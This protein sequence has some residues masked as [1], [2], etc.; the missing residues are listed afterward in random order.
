MATPSI[1]IIPSIF[2]QGVLGS[3]LPLNGAAD[4]DFT[5]ASSA[6]RVNKDGLIETVSTGV[7]RLDYSDGGCPVLLIEPQSTNLITFSEDLSNASWS[8]SNITVTA[9]IAISPKG[10]LDAVK[11]SET[12][13]TSSF[14]VRK[15]NQTVTGNRYTYS[16]FAKKG[17][18]TNVILGS[19]N[20]WGYAIFDLELGVVTNVIDNGSSAVARIKLI[21]NGWYLCVLTATSVSDGSFAVNIF[22]NSVSYAGDP[23][24]GLYIWGAQLE[25]QNFATSYIPTLGA[26]VTRLADV[27]T[28][29]LTPFTLTSI[30][31]TIGDVEQTPITV[32]PSTYTVPFGKIN[33]IIME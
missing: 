20:N 14:S 21:S 32:I 2:K 1:A 28:L 23:S 10:S 24:K 9:N 27:A 30:T 4:L 5:R 8:K 19:S 3:V 25:Q 6:T 16:I 12:N 18:R 22:N 13:I 31:E 29:D 7:P 26:I 33:K 15:T 17:E 11:L